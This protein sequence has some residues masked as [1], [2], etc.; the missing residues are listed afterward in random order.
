MRKV[1]CL[2]LALFGLIEAQTF[3]NNAQGQINGLDYELW[4]DTGT[5]SMTLLGGGKFKCSWSN[6]NNCL[7]RI[8]K[9]WNCKYDWWDLGTV[10]V[11]Y[12]VDYNPN[13]NSYLCIYGWLK[14]PL[15]EYYIV[16]SW[17]SWRP[18]GGSPKKTIYVDDGAY[19]VYVTDRI[20]Q[21]SIEGNT[22]FKQYWSVRTGKKTRGKVTVSHHFYN[23]Q[24]M[25]LT[26][27]KV[28]EASLNIEGY[29]SQGSATVNKND[30]S[31]SK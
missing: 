7:F 27:G 14:N 11:D 21:P 8:G 19:D 20:N 23:W 16:E 17:G 2:L 29:Q 3:Y 6:I 10:T 5:T 4:K 13:G 30:V 18:P 15:V 22:N 12:D 25:G 26:V 9:K 24:E 28:Y 31:S 1:I